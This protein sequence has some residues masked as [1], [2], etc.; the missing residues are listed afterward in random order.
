MNPEIRNAAIAGVL[1][2]AAGAGWYL[3]YVQPREEFLLAVSDC[4]SEA[5]AHSD[6]KVEWDRCVAAMRQ[7]RVQ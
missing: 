3:G 1:L 5:P 4:T 6:P 7:E 2:L